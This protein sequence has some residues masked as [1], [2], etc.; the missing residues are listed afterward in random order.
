M[1]GQVADGKKRTAGTDPGA[2]LGRAMSLHQAGRLDEAEAAYLELLRRVPDHP[3][4][5]NLAG[6][7]AHQLGRSDE[8]KARLRRAVAVQPDFAAAWNHLGLVLY[9]TGEYR[10]AV[11]TL[12]RAAELAPADLGVLLNLGLA[13]QDV[14]RLQEAEGTFRRAL[15]LSPD[16]VPALIN[17]GG[18]LNILNRPSESEPLLRRAAALDPGSAS[19]ALNLGL[20]FQAR[21]RAAEAEAQYDRAL[22]LDPGNVQARW[23]RSLL[24]L[25]RGDL[26][27]GWED[28]EDRFAAGT[29]HPRRRFR[30][31]R[32]RGEDI[33]GR[34]LLVW[35]EQG[36][37]D[38][39]L[40]GGLY[41]EA[42]RRAGRVIIEADPR[43]VP[44]FRRSFPEATVREE[45]GD[46]ADAD[47]HVPAGSLPGL[48][49]RRLSDFPGESGWLKPDPALTERWA[50]RLAALGPGLK[51]GICWTSGLIA[52]ERMGNY[53]RL[54]DWDPLLTLPGIVPVNLQYSDCAAEIAAAERRTGVRLAGWPDLDLRGDLD[55]VAALVA[56]LDLVVSA[57]TS[58]GEL[59]GA[60]GVPV[61]RL[62]AGRDWTGLG[63]G[64]RPWFPSMRTFEAGAEGLAGLPARAAHHLAALARPGPAFA[65]DRP[66]TRSPVRVPPPAPVPQ[67]PP[68]GAAPGAKAVPRTP[69]PSPA[70]LPAPS[71]AEALAL[72][73]AG[74]AAEAEAAYRAVLA[75]RPADA[76]A[77]H[78]L[79][80][81]RFQAG[82]A[83][84]AEALI[85]RAAAERPG[86]AT[87]ENN[88]ANILQAAGRFAEAEARYAAAL[89][90]R[91]DFAEALSNRGVALQ[92]LGRLAEA[93]DCH[94]RAVAL[95]PD[96]AEGW[97]NL[98][99]ALKEAGRLGEA[100]SC[101]RRAAALAPGLA[102]AHTNLGTCLRAQ[103]RTREADAAF[104]AAL[105]LELG[106]PL[107]RFNRALGALETGR[108]AEG[109]AGYEHR[110]SARR[111][112]PARRLA[113]PR[114]QGG[115]ARGRR[116]L[117][118]REQGLGDEIM[119]SGLYRDL[120]ARVGHL[121]VECDPRLQGL[122]S[123]ALP[124]ATV[125]AA[126]PDPRDAEL[127]VPAGSLPGLLRP[128]LAGFDGRPWLAPDPALAAR[129]AA[130]LDALGPG[131]R[132]GI[133][134]RSGLRTAEREGLYSRLEDWAPL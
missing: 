119:F 34:T 102:L 22:A 75:V 14:N 120:Q 70:P 45:T 72:H 133:C 58:V 20:S 1:V 81:L 69:V 110:F 42:I 56:S 9:Q 26:A 94:R 64:A 28:Y 57:P 43:L 127:E 59:A 30:I 32:W 95:R 48:F 122:L 65:P 15:S 17:L 112:Q 62:G 106:L 126:T 103:G 24:R 85:A 117:V 19:A 93:E 60:L 66:G 80:L 123:R 100:E 21:G 77:L 3:D 98:G 40:F 63:T 4:A 38:E 12:T 128:G 51:V 89:A 78:L 105:A 31:P 109:W 116:V 37:G 47:L 71:L 49:R 44:L 16:H 23:D 35:R 88:L 86:F 129:W 13:L 54:S 83:A 33:A 53:T 10:A 25:G 87:A 99:A 36:I 18:L 97:T 115:D 76:D 125:R 74:R 124:G 41:G 130:R 113:M 68:A 108:L 101:H 114:W 52:L 7:A 29:V 55:G 91:P 134:W 96:W 79:G 121:V 46:P 104:D 27:G 39:F 6:V 8:G 92:E 90:A 84:D 82:D 2:L 67:P 131:L 5:L 73:E 61:W 50:A 132:V 11:E 107:A 111:R 118:W